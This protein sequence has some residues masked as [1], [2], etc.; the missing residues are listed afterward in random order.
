[1]LAYIGN[2]FVISELGCIASVLM[3]SNV[4]IHDAGTALK[5]NFK[6]QDDFMYGDDGYDL[7]HDGDSSTQGNLDFPNINMYDLNIN[8]TLFLVGYLIYHFFIC[9]LS[10]HSLE[11]PSM[12]H[13]DMTIT[14]LLWDTTIQI[15]ASK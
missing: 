6:R 3:S 4:E 5:G 7:L 14:P 2:F 15:L 1:M 11:N 8:I 10:Y 13:I 9:R 12:F